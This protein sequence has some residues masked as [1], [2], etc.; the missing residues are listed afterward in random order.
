MTASSCSSA[1][2]EPIESS[3]ALCQSCSVPT[4]SSGRTPPLTVTAWLRWHVV[5]PLL[6]ASGRVLD[7][8]AGLGSYGSMLA[9]RFEYTGVEP[10]P[11]SYEEAKRRIGERG[12]LVN[13][14][15][16]HLE[17]HQEYDLVCAFEVLEHIENDRAALRLWARH[18]R[19]GGSLLVSVPRGPERF[20][21]GDARYGHFRRYTEAGLVDLMQQSE[22]ADVQTKVYGSPWGNTVE[23]IRN[24]VF[25]VLSSERSYADRTAASGRFLQPPSWTARVTFGLSVPLSYVQGSFA[26]RGIGTGVIALG[27]RRPGQA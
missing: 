17:P 14:S 4:S 18:V 27:R 11:T 8:G 1:S 6:P 20:G 26:R 25:R 9:D 23:A 19:P 2:R 3:R 5:E 21:P 16:E 15:I 13:C 12:T 7:I 24:G 10:D 22:L